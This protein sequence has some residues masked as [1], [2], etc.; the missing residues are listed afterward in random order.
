MC[1]CV[2]V[3]VCVLVCVF[4]LCVSCD[5][6]SEEGRPMTP[7]GCSGHMAVSH[8][9]ADAVVVKSFLIFLRVAAS[10]GSVLSF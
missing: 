1:V 5:S 3:C 9:L 10:F 7:F 2:Y 6:L 4:N 8:T